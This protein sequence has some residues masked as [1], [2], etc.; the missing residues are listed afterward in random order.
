MSLAGVACTLAVQ[1]AR[2]A[3]RSY[4][5]CFVGT[6]VLVSTGGG[7]CPTTADITVKVTPYEE[8]NVL[9]LAL[10]QQFNG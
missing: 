10:H 1:M 7:L 3:L 2:Y 6:I 9:V 8:G 5:R 4:I